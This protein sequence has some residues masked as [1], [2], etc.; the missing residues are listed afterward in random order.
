[1]ASAGAT[2]VVSGEAQPLA[3]LLG[4]LAAF[5]AKGVAHCHFKSNQHLRAALA[6]D[7]DLDLLV[8]R[9]GARAAQALLAAHGFKR[10]DPGLATGYPAV[11]DWIGFDAPTGRLMHLHVHYRLPIGE[12]HLKSYRLPFADALLATRV[13]DAESFAWTS[14]P[15]HELLLLLVRHALKLG[16]RDRLGALAGRR[17]A[18]A[19]GARREYDWLRER[20]EPARVLALAERELG[21]DVAARLAPLLSGEPELAALLRLRRTVAHALAPFRTWGAPEAWLR[22]SAREAVQRATRWLRRR[23]IQA[24]RAFRR[25]NPTGGSVIAFVGCDGSGK[26]TLLAETSRWLGWKLD[27]LPIYFGSGDG[28]VSFWRKP[29]VLVRGLQKRV[30]KP[31]PP[32]QR[33]RV[34]APR[35]PSPARAV[36][37]LVLAREKAARLRTAER[38]RQRGLV[39]LCDRYPQSTVRGFNDGPLLTPWLESPRALLRRLARWE[40]SVYE[41]ARALA[42][43]LVIKLDVSPKVAV[44]R[45]PEMAAEECARRRAAVSALEWGGRGR[46]VTVDAEQ[47]LERVIAEVKRAVWAEL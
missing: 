21:A 46:V 3:T 8:A 37:A 31:R 22:R 41:S 45:K 17:P 5:D 33:S 1:M 47:P 39:V 10:F 19:G 2:E 11:E 6:G 44:Q 15:H 18:L 42:P 25:T 38:A 4:V 12:L 40:L 32:E 36:W 34:L 9:S 13:R 14:E 20:C 30:S 29:L 43:D 27:V 26:S 24:P 28:P 7:T 35:P 16:F 23:R